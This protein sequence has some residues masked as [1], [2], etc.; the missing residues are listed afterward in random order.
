M[1]EF[2]LI[3]TGRDRYQIDLLL[4]PMGGGEE[5]VIHVTMGEMIGLIAYMDVIAEF[6]NYQKNPEDF[7]LSEHIARLLQGESEKE[8]ARLRRMDG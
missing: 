8:K 2:N 7:I 3:V 1:K 4:S 6:Y 5:I